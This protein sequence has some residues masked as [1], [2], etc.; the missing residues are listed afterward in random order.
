MRVILL[1]VV[2][3]DVAMLNV[4]EPCLMIIISR[5]GSIFATLFGPLFESSVL[6]VDN[7]GGGENR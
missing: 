7:W 2:M 3:L 1:N 4:V 5:D 6:H